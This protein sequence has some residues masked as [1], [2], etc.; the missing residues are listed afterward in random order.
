MNDI[1]NDEYRL[2]VAPPSLPKGWRRFPI[3][4]ARILYAGTREAAELVTGLIRSNTATASTL[5][6]KLSYIGEHYAVIAYYRQ[7][8]IAAVDHVRSFPIFWKDI[9][10]TDEVVVSPDAHSLS[11]ATKPVA[12]D[13]TALIELAMS[14]FVSGNNTLIPKIAQ[15]EA[16]EVKLWTGS[17]RI[18]TALSYKHWPQKY[19]TFPP[20][21]THERMTLSVD[22]AFD[23]TM[24]KADGKPILVPLSGGL[25]SRIVLAKLVEKG[26][27]P[28]RAFSYGPRWNADA[29]IARKVASRLGV[30]WTY[31]VT[32]GQRARTLLGS[33]LLL[34]YWNFADGLCAIPN[35]QDF[36]P[37][38]TLLETGAISTDTLI[39]NGQT[40]DFITGGHI[41]FAFT[42]T[43]NV[44]NT[45]LI[46]AIVTKHY[47]LWQHLMTSRNLSTIEARLYDQ[48]GLDSNLPTLSAETAAAIFEL[49]EYRERQA[50]YVVNGQRIYDFLGLGWSLPL[51]DREFVS[52]CRDIPLKQKVNQLF[53][54]N[55]LTEWDYRGVFS[56]ISSQATAWPNLVSKAISP[57]AIGLRLALGRYNRDRLFRYLYYFDR[58]GDQYKVFGFRTFAKH[59]QNLRNPTSLY[60]KAWL[61]YRGV[62]LNSLISK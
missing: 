30:P 11:Q 61:E 34:D 53:Y 32:S 24:N 21:T 10:N 15:L 8:I 46:E 22:Q 9:N 19:Q 57:L 31:V 17:G 47:S 51:W 29:A 42:H 12:F 50:K 16:G 52:M 43:K 23:R 26:Y 38:V 56:N 33:Q 54:K 4:D 41:P 40:G 62:E 6:G 2:A 27:G 49:W 35:H 1:V 20:E 60:A 59:A 18:E 25:D 37:L 36:L 45:G 48:L 58:F 39:V 44:T 13:P 14:G 7:T 28:L 55:W 3:S 5:A